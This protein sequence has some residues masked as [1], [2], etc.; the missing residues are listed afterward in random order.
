MHDAKSS[1]VLASH[2]PKLEASRRPYVELVAK[3]PGGTLP[4]W[5]SKA[6]D[7]PYLPK[8][9]KYP[10]IDGEPLLPYAQIA[11]EEVPPLDGFPRRRLLS[12]F[13]SSGMD[14]SKVLYFPNIERDAS[15][16]HTDFSFL[17]WEELWQSC[18]FGQGGP[19][20][21]SFASKVGCVPW[22]D[23]HFERLLGTAAVEALLDSPEYME[24]AR[25]VA[26]QSNAFCDHLAAMPAPS[27]RTR[28]RRRRTL[29]SKPRSCSS[30]RTTF[31]TTGSSSQ[32]R[33]RAP[34][35]RA[36]STAQ[37]ATEHNG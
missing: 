30:R 29:G 16:L 31:A 14:A 26:A 33:W 27:R 9:L 34:T 1:T 17:E 24:A 28:A 10:K 35:S 15:K 23:H 25:W 13:V 7:A 32:Q 18:P 6:C 8:K 21:L 11:L 12:F 36:C 37:R 3:K 20:A 22:G 5:A 4:P 19:V 2:L